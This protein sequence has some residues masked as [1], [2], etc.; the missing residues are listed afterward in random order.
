MNLIL[1]FENNNYAVVKETTCDQI[2]ELTKLNLGSSMNFT[3]VPH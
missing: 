3:L 2:L 1:L